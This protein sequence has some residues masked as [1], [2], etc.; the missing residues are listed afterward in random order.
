MTQEK[1]E[2]PRRVNAL[3]EG[4]VALE[5]QPRSAVLALQELTIINELTLIRGWTLSR[6]IAWAFFDQQESKREDGAAERPLKPNYAYK[7]GQLYLLYYIDSLWRDSEPSS[8]FSKPSSEKLQTALHLFLQTG[9]K[10]EGFG[11]EGQSLSTLHRKAHKDLT[12]VYTVMDFLVRTYHLYRERGLCRLNIARYF[13]EKF[14]PTKEDLSKSSIEK[15]WN[16]YRDAAPYIYGSY[17]AMY[18]AD[19]SRQRSGRIGIQN[20]CRLDQ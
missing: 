17:P 2:I 4:S 13:V 8:I 18:P 11:L 15:I 6:L 19:C 10:R 16:R 9:E 3:D 14:V 1:S 7:S 20:G 5:F 12:V